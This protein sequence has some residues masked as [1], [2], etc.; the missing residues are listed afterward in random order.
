MSHPPLDAAYASLPS[1][2]ATA[3]QRLALLPVKDVDVALAAAVCGGTYADVSALDRTGTGT[4]T[5][6]DSTLRGLLNAHLGLAQDTP[7]ADATCWHLARSAA[8]AATLAPAQTRDRG[9]FR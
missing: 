8:L 4:G 7:S 1:Q 2:A 6:N 3:C 5:G 9:G